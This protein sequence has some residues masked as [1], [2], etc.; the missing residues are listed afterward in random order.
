VIIQTRRPLKLIVVDSVMGIL[1]EVS[2]EVLEFS[3][4]FVLHGVSLEGKGIREKGKE[5]IRRELM[6]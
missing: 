5:V 6:E 2:H 4:I 1:L 3:T